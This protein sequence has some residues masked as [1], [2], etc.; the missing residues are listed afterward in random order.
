[1]ERFGKEPRL[2][3]VRITRRSQLT[4]LFASPIVKSLSAAGGAGWIALVIVSP[5]ELGAAWAH[6]FSRLREKVARPIPLAAPCCG[7]ALAAGRATNPSDAVSQR[8]R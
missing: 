1:M 3:A 5:I 6:P 4:I 7:G 2:R 8:A